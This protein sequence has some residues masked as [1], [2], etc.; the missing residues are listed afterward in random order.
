[1]SSLPSIEIGFTSDR[2]VAVRTVAVIVPR[3]PTVMRS[4]AD[5]VSCRSRHARPSGAVY[6]GGGRRGQPADLQKRVV[7]S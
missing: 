1:M 3:A 2:E 6:G 5:S 4:A 7:A